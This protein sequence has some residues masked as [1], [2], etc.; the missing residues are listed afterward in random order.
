MATY[1]L[2]KPDFATIISTC[3]ALLADDKL[4]VY[5]FGCNHDLTLHIY[6]D[7]NHNPVKDK[8]YAN[9]VTIHTQKDNIIVDDTNDTYVTDGAL[10]REL[11]RIHFYR[12]FKTL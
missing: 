6:K 8:E 5:H 3:N 1:T 12:D 4:D 9:I 7:S 10:F 2:D 11:N